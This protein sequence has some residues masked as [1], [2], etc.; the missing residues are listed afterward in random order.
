[1]NIENLEAFVYVIH[2]GS[3]NRAAE[4]LFL[5]QP[6]VTARI[7]SLERELDC[8]LFDRI[9]KQAVLTEEGKR[10]LPYAQQIIQ[11]YQK[12]K[13]HVQQKRRLTG[14]LR[15]GCTVSVSNYVIPELLPLLKKK[16]PRLRFKF[17][18]GVT[19]ELVGK[20]LNKEVDIGLV[21]NV[22]HP[23]LTSVKFFEDPIRLHVYADHPFIGNEALTIEAIGDQPL[24]FFECGALDWQRIH[25]IFETLRQP[26][27]VEIQTDNSEMAKK[28]VMERAGICFLPSLCVRREVAEGKL[29]AIDFPETAGISMQT[30]IV[31]PQGEHEEL[32]RELLQIG[33]ELS[34]SR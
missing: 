15:I 17:V 24:V 13:Q 20:V 28:L 34:L 10:F 2:L 6:S 3:F 26:P 27:N 21:R 4:A 33:R 25:R 18:T 11:T 7:Q 31:A 22:T 8:R 12:G 1:M 32:V 14:E 30:N 5:S 16:Y 23:N 9:G 19:D 29:F